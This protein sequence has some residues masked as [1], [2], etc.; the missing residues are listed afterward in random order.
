MYIFLKTY[1][2]Y[3]A[4]VGA[5]A[6]SAKKNWQHSQQ[7]LLSKVDTDIKIFQKCICK[8]DIKLLKIKGL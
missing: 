8:R 1:Q 6:T 7:L 5:R 3:I 4:V 2:V